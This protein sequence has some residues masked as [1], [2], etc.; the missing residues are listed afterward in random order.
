VNL[1]LEEGRVI[2]CL[3]EKQLTT[4]QQ[5]PLTL[6]A[7]TAACNQSSNRDPVVYYEE[8]SIEQALT[9]LKDSGLVRFVHPSHGR[10]VT[11][12]AQ[13]IGEQLALHDRRLA[14]LAVLLLRG[15]QTAGELRAR[16]E[17]MAPFEG[18]GGVEE[19][20]RAMSGGPEPL[21]ARLPRRPG[22]KEERWAQLLA[23]GGD[24]A[25]GGT[26][27]VGQRLEPALATPEASRRPGTSAELA[28]APA[29]TDGP[30]LGGVA[31]VAGA[32]GDAFAPGGPLHPVLD[33]REQLAVIAGDVA[34]L[35]AEVAALHA[36]LETLQARLFQ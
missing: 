6:N 24:A 25:S 16:T 27:E 4:P 26:V 29:L 17:R 15:S 35:R 13:V 10:S 31:D 36:A 11:R 3:I 20:L 23:P 30:A 8:P 32:S 12:Y 7:L 9:R 34:S 19:E 33:V 5:Y 18:I 14:I 1:G 28:A 21:T 22:Q 2:G